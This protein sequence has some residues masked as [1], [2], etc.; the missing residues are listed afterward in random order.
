MN[1]KLFVNSYFKAMS[2]GETP[3]VKDRLEMPVAT[4]KTDTGLT[5]GLLRVL[6]KQVCYLNMCNWSLFCGQQ[7]TS[8]M[9][10]VNSH[11]CNN[12]VFMYKNNYVKKWELQNCYMYMKLYVVDIFQYSKCFE[13][14]TVFTTSSTK[15][16]L[17]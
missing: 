9:G 17:F 11:C 7:L 15:M 16:L 1:V 5:P 14:H 8:A 4:Q 2:K 10:Q 12:H 3:P 13:F 6:N